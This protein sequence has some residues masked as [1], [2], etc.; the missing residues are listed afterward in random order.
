MLPRTP[1]FLLLTASLLAAPPFQPPQLHTLS[2]LYEGIHNNASF[3][4]QQFSTDD[5][6]T[7]RGTGINSVTGEAIRGALVQIYF[8]G[9][10]SIPPLPHSNFHCTRLPPRPP[11]I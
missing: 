3:Q 10:R 9:Q 6:N 4:S 8:N 2:P 7:L 11:T 5:K 1:L